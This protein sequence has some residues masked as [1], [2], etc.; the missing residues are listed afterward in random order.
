MMVGIA[1]FCI[2]F[3]GWVYGIHPPVGWPGWALAKSHICPGNVYC[4]GCWYRS[5][6]DPGSIQDRSRIDPEAIQGRSSR[7]R[8]D[9]GSIHPIDHESWIDPSISRFSYSRGWS[10]L[11]WRHNLPVEWYLLNFI[12]FQHISHTPV[13]SLSV[14]CRH[15]LLNTDIFP[16]SNS[17]IVDYS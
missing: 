4:V 15:T 5:R 12:S 8:I 1:L 2:Y 3:R 11:R 17:T 14:K 7:Y 10:C 9:P 13:S 16:P 6:I